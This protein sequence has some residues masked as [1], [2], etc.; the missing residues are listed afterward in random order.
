MKRVHNTGHGAAQGSTENHQGNIMSIG[1]SIKSAITL[2]P[3]LPGLALE[4]AE[5]AGEGYVGFYFVYHDDEGE[6]G[7]W[8]YWISDQADATASNTYYSAQEI[9]ELLKSHGF[10]EKNTVTMFRAACTSGQ[11]HWEEYEVTCNDPSFAA[12]AAQ[13]KFTL[14]EVLA[15]ADGKNWQSLRQSLSQWRE[16]IERTEAGF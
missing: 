11:H 9:R 6:D 8:S 12:L 1:T 2:D 16:N 3:A 10:K 15:E 4:A 7:E 5:A 14:D 13:F